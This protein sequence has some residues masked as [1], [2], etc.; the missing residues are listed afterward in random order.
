MY[1][2]KKQF[3]YQTAR[4]SEKRKNNME[5]I[6]KFKFKIGILLKIIRILRKSKPTVKFRR[7]LVFP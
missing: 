3:C 2:F 4:K 7:L 1:A 6:F 5:N